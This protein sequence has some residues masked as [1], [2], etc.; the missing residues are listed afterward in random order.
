MNAN[1]EPMG[2]DTEESAALNITKTLIRGLSERERDR[3]LGWMKARYD[4]RGRELQGY[5]NTD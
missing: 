3:L 4:V 1:N 2:N 5:Q